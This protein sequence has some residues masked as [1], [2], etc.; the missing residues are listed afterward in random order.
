MP[1]KIAQNRELFPFV[2]LIQ[3]GKSVK[4][5][6]YRFD[7]LR[8]FPG[9]KN[10]KYF[11]RR[12]RI[13]YRNIF[14]KILSR[15]CCFVFAYMSQ[16]PVHSRFPRH[17]ITLVVRLYYCHDVVEFRSRRCRVHK[18]RRVCWHRTTDVPLL[19][20]RANQNEPCTLTRRRRRAYSRAFCRAGFVFSINTWYVAPT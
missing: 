16:F 6:C 19:F 8:N 15:D 10:G 17:C 20:N 11:T 3:M 7:S 2:T 1:I 18:R 13:Y 9:T 4:P 12:V 5:D 14:S